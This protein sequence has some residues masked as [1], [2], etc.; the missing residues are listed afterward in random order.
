MIAMSRLIRGVVLFALHSLS[1]VVE[2]EG[3]KPCKIGKK[4]SD[5]ERVTFW[6]YLS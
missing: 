1:S 6:R 5:Y 3:E 4:N 2:S